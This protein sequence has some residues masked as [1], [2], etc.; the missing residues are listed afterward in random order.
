MMYMFCKQ[1]ESVQSVHML[2]DAL[3]AVAMMYRGTRLQPD[4]FQT[5]NSDGLRRG[6]LLSMGPESHPPD[7]HKDKEAGMYGGPMPLND[8]AHIAWKYTQG[9]LLRC[10][11]ISHLRNTPP[12]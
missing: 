2:G 1:I 9:R 5:D 11:S 10:H 12:A 7:A 8:Y 3:Q 6:M 4:V